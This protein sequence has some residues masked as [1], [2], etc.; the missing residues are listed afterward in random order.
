MVI[1]IVDLVPGAIYVEDSDVTVVEAIFAAN[2]AGDSGGET[3]FK[4]MR[5]QYSVMRSWTGTL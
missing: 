4:S 3:Y 5:M 1:A 2:A